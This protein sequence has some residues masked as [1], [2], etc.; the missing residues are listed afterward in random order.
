MTLSKKLVRHNI[1]AIGVAVARE[2]LVPRANSMPRAIEAIRNGLVEV[3]RVV[4]RG[5]DGTIANN[6]LF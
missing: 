1:D 6:N 2:E 5:K 3:L 4:V